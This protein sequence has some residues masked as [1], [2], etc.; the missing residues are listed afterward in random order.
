MELT[1]D[2][3]AVLVDTRVV[4]LDAAHVEVIRVVRF[5][6]VVR[7]IRDVLTRVRFTY[8]GVKQVSTP[9]YLPTLP[10]NHTRPRYVYTSE[11]ERAKIR[12]GQ[13][14]LPPHEIKRLHEVLPE[15]HKVLRDIFLVLDRGGYALGG[16]REA[17]AHRLVDPDHVRHVRPAPRVLD[18]TV[19]AGLPEER[20]DGWSVSCLRC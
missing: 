17:R 10:R 19:C 20:L 14:H 18:R 7:D 16:R 6:H 13:V 1:V 9:Q 4:D 11:R 3:H 2:H 12:T 15:P 5:E 8:G